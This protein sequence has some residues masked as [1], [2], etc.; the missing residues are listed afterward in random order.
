MA[1]DRESPFILGDQSGTWLSLVHERLQFV[2]RQ[3]YMLAS[4]LVSPVLF[5]L[6]GTITDFTNVVVMS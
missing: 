2:I 6:S 4:E 5:G 1:P 3:L